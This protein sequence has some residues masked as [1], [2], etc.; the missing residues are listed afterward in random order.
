MTDT[1]FRSMSDAEYRELRAYRAQ[2]DLAI[3]AGYHTTRYVIIPAGDRPQ[4][5]DVPIEHWFDAEG[6]AE[7][8][9]QDQILPHDWQIIEV[10]TMPVGMQP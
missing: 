8:F 9:R 10:T 3:E 2:L 5:Y 4:L 1:D 6:I 7:S